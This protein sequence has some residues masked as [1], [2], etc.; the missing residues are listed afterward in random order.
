MP[1][2]STD[3]AELMKRIESIENRV[4]EMEKKLD[5]VNL[6]IKQPNLNTI[7]IPIN[8]WLDK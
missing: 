5:V 7:R 1:I 3:E 2:R 4:K 8:T 6:E